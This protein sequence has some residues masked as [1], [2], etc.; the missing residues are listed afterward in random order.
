MDQRPLTDGATRHPSRE[1]LKHPLKEFAAALEDQTDYEHRW[2]INPKTGEVVFWT[3]DG[4]IDGHTSVDLDDL[5]LVV[6][7]PLPSYAGIRTWL[8]SPNGSVTRR[9]AAGS[10]E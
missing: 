7:D 6:V 4:G 3:T 10:P 8:T 2:L 9:L 1:L 5:D